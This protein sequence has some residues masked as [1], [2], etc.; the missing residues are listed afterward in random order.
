MNYLSFSKQ[1][2]EIGIRLWMRRKRADAFGDG[3]VVV[4][5]SLGLGAL[6]SQSK[7]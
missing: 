7:E 4:R 3:L 5:K 1:Q 2:A 6:G